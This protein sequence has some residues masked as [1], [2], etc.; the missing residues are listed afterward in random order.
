MAKTVEEKHEVMS[1]EQAKAPVKL[2]PE[3]RAAVEEVLAELRALPKGTTLPMSEISRLL[4][5]MPGRPRNWTSA[6]VIRELRGPLPEDDPNF[7]LIDGKYVPR[8]IRELTSEEDDA[9]QSV[10]RDLDALPAGTTLTIA[11]VSALLRRLPGRTDRHN[12]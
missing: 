9:V 5:K 2:T 10:L 3:Q 4:R 1:E 6:D 7:E 8:R 12:A 11:E